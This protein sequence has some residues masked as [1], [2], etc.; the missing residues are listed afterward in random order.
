MAMPANA[1]ENRI[2]L[3]SLQAV[4]SQFGWWGFK[5]FTAS[6]TQTWNGADMRP[7]NW[8]SWC[9]GEPNNAGGNE[10]CA[11]TWSGNTCWNDINCGNSYRAICVYYA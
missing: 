6:D 9:N 10:R 1:E 2:F 11:M 7:M 4:T 3:D 8:S 5:R